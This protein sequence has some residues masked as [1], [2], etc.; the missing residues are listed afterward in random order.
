MD[1]RIPWME[2]ELSRYVSTQ[3]CDGGGV[4]DLLGGQDEGPS[5]LPFTAE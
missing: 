3:I 4:V 1:G 2:R 5:L